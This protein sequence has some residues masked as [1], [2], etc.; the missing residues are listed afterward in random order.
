MISNWLHDY[1]SEKSHN[2]LSV[3]QRSR[4]ASS[5]I[6]S[7]YKGRRWD[8]RTQAGRQETK[9][10]KSFLSLGLLLYLDLQGILGR[11]IHFEFTNSISNLTHKHLHRHTQ[12]CLV[13]V[14]HGQS[15]WH[16]KLIIQLGS[17][18]RSSSLIYYCW[19]EFRNI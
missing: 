12:K 8:V 19:W 2:L 9:R 5:V 15:N 11:A 3:N 1:E 16:I 7:K 17:Y 13:W 10:S 4:K 18:R 14:P 6:Y